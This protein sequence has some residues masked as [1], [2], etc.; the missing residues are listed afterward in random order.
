MVYDK[1]NKWLSRIFSHVWRLLTGIV[2][3]NVN[4]CPWN[5]RFPCSRERSVCM[6]PKLKTLPWL[7]C[8]LPYHI[9]RHPLCCQ[10]PLCVSSLYC[11]SRARSRQIRRLCR[12]RLCTALD[13]GRPFCRCSVDSW[14]GLAP[15]RVEAS[16]DS[17]LERPDVRGNRAWTGFM[18]KYWHF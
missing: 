10:W 18:D 12:S 15:W 6:A 13:D 16:G 3:K 8:F 11:H 7:K 9:R 17:R 2:V 1:K 14:K 4:I 5:Q